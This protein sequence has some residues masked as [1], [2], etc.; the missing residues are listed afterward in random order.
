MKRSTA[1]IVQLPNRQPALR[2]RLFFALLCVLLWAATWATMPLTAWAQAQTPGAYD[3][4]YAATAGVALTVAAPGVLANDVAPAGAT[5]TSLVVNSNPAHGTVTLNLNGAF[6]YTPVANYNG[7]DNFVYRSTYSNGSTF[8]GIVNLT[9]RLVAALDDSYTVSEDQVLTVAA[10]GVL[11]NDQG[12]AGATLTSLVVNS[13]PAHGAVTLNLNG[14]FVY[15]PAANYFGVD[16]FG[17][18]STYS[19]GTILL[20]LVNLTVLPVIDPVRL[21][22]DHYTI[23]EDSVLQ[24]A[25]PGIFAN[26]SNPDGL[27]VT[28]LVVTANPTHGTLVLNQDGSFTY[29]PAANF[30]G[31]DFFRY[32]VTHAG[33][34]A[35]TGSVTIAVTPVTDVPVVMD[36]SFSGN[37][38]QSIGGTVTAN[39]QNV[40]NL[41]ILSN[42]VTQNPS[43]GTLF[44]SN[45][46]F[47]YTPQFDFTGTD[48][49]IYQ[50]TYAG[51]IIKTG[52]VNLTVNNSGTTLVRLVNV[53]SGKC[54]DVP[55]ANFQAGATLIQFSCHGGANQTFK[56]TRLSNGAYE[57]AA[58]TLL[59]DIPGGSTANG[60]PVSL[61]TPNG[62]F[63]NQRFLLERQGSGNYL[64]RAKHSNLVFDVNGGSTADGAGVI[65]WPLHGGA[66]QLWQVEVVN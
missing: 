36:D 53:N 2:L 40:D 51:N 5:L 21:G 30:N 65:Q 55:S 14:A 23:A 15:T 9:V 22:A 29:T 46:L 52:V 7:S 45:G 60:A 33:Q 4:S 31:D 54:L 57:I 64:I 18:Q 12:P 58:S 32:D 8:L 20:G 28:S 47:A 49:F 1:L 19:N 56:L 66:N 48:Q 25:A 41:A 10:P 43:Y 38:N 61:W 6:T 3:D 62:G 37:K 26:D 27:A 63:D 39:D 13:N 35:Q 59:L 17:Y 42:V 44:Y 24:V 11:S 50:V 34:S 16:R